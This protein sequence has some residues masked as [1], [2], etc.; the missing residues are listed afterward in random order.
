MRLLAG[1]SSYEVFADKNNLSKIQYFK[2]E[3]GTNFTLKSLDRVL[4][5]HDISIINFF[6]KFDKETKNPANIE[7]VE[8]ITMLL[9]SLQQSKLVFSKSL[10]LSNANQINAILSG[11]NNISAKLAYQIEKVY[12]QFKFSWILNGEGEMV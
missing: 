6:H 3:K 9:D 5:I 2:M 8:R 10:G 12:P 4:K 11:R 1:F 7:C